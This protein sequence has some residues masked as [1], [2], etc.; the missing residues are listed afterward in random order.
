[1]KLHVQGVWQNVQKIIRQLTQV[2][3]DTDQYSVVRR[4]MPGLVGLMYQPV[5]MTLM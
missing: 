3:T 5:F 4:C 1:M 2:P